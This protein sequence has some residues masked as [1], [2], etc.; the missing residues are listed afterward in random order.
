[1]TLL[2]VSEFSTTKGTQPPTGMVRGCFFLRYPGA[3]W[4]HDK[5]NYL[6]V[7]SN[8]LSSPSSENTRIAIIG[9][10][11]VGLPLAIAFAKKYDV[12]GFDIDSE[13]VDSLKRGIDRTNEANLSDLKRVLDYKQ[14]NHQQYDSP[15]LSL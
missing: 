9:L 13:R 10:G 1:M 15:G 8:P 7:M 5:K 12:L 2:G 4:R 11:Y 14:N 3:T 6:C